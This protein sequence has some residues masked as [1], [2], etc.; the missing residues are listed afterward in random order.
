[1]KKEILNGTF[2]IRKERERDYQVVEDIIR[3]A[4]YNL[5]VPGANEH[6][7]AHVMRGHEDFIP[8]LSLV[9]EREEEVIGS[10]MYTK[11]KLIDEAGETKQI[12][13]FGP[14][15]VLPQYQRSGAGKL[16]ME[17]SFEQAIA[18]GYDVIVIFGS[19]SN[20]VSRGFQC[21]KKLQVCVEG[22]TY[23]TAMMVKE[24][25]PGALG[26]KKWVYHESPVM[27][28]DEAEAELFDAALPEMEK[29]YLPRQEEFAILSQSVIQ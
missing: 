14:V 3:K 2:Q 29:K 23:P 13:T 11:T 19:P 9:I 15:C 18:L 21:C 24:L 27:Q 16:L 8:E 22:G 4:F 28:V 1:M 6:Y 10:I 5:Y 12:L 26:G 7:L 20:Y 17:Y 25:K